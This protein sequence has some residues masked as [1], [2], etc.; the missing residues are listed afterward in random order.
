MPDPDLP[1]DLTTVWHPIQRDRFR[2]RTW[3]EECVVLDLFSGDTHAFDALS[4]AV[5]HTLLAN[6]SSTAKVGYA[7]A[8]RLALDCDAEFM[9]ATEQALLRFERLGIAERRTN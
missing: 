6:A 5:F 9:A 8:E 4:A 7:A 2:L 3:A 1:T